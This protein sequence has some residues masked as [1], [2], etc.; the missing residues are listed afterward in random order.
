MTSKDINI[1]P[2]MAKSIVK[3]MVPKQKQGH[4]V[5]NANKRARKN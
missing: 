2:P 3:L 5:K 4:R 1:A